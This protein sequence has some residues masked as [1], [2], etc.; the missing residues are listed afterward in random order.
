M[1]VFNA[2]NPIENITFTSYNAD[3]TV[4]GSTPIQSR[5]A[6]QTY[7]RRYLYNM[8]L[9]IVEADVLDNLL[10]NNANT[11]TSNDRLID[12]GLVH[13]IEKQFLTIG[14]NQAQQK[15][16][17]DKFGVQVIEALT[18]SQFDAFQKGLE[19]LGKAIEKQKAQA[20]G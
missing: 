11:A 3:A 20:N 8:A 16:L 19:G 18:E 10:N 17:L 6:L 15:F 13:S 9:E 4:K 2:S 7:Q 12:A 1:Q 5:G 14:A